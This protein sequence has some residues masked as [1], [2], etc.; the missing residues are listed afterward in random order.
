MLHMVLRQNLN[1]QSSY[2]ARRLTR[3]HRDRDDRMVAIAKSNFE[4]WF[5][6]MMMGNCTVCLR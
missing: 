2:A 5:V 1:T 6:K 4:N 3:T